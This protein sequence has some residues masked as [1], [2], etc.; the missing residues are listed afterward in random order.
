[1]TRAGS[2]QTPSWRPARSL[3]GLRADRDRVFALMIPLTTSVVW[4]QQVEDLHAS[5]PGCWLDDELDVL[6]SLRVFWDLIGN[7][8]P[9]SVSRS[10]CRFFGIEA[11]DVLT[12]KLP[13]D[14]LM[15]A[16]LWPFVR[17]VQ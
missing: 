10:L 12:C 16:T 13:N 1:M 14:V 4:I 7:S 8:L 15:A 2:F 3:E 6:F 5:C 17:E 9:G 11:G